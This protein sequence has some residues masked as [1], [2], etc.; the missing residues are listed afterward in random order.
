MTLKSFK[1]NATIRVTAYHCTNGDEEKIE[2]VTLGAYFTRGGKSYIFYEETEQIGMENSTVML[3][4]EKDKVTF[5]RSGTGRLKLTYVEGES[6][7]VLYY[8]PFG[9]MNITQTTKSV[10]CRLDDAGGSVELWY[11][12][13][14][15]RDKQENRLY[16]KVER[17]K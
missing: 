11:T 9:A 7:N 8:F 3:I 15:G 14:M 1:E 6:E 13:C 17:Q 5:K 10:R 12:L 4:C 16:I 2:F